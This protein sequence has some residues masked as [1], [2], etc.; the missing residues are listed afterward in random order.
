MNS[1]PKP[2]YIGLAVALFLALAYVVARRPGGASNDPSNEASHAPAT[3]DTTSPMVCV[4]RIEPLGGEVDV[5]AQMAGTLE[6]VTVK[7]GDRVEAG[8]PMASVEAR[9]EKAQ[10][11]LAKARLTRVQAGF[12]AEEIAATA[13]QRDAVAAELSLAESELRRALKLKEQNVISDDD[14]ETRQQRVAS[15]TKQVASLQKQFEAMKRGPLPEEV[16]VARAEVEVARANYQ[17]HEVLAPCGGTVLQLYRHTGDQVL[18]NYPTPILRMADTNRLQVRVEVNEAD[19]YRL[20]AG[21]EGSFTALGL[22]SETGRL[23]VR[24]VLPA[25]GPKRLFDPDTAAR[26]DTRTLQVLCDVTKT[27]QLVYPGQRVIVTFLPFRGNDQG[28]S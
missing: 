10:F 14:M 2:V 23:R 26:V 3:D 22:Q 27:R 5:S 18:L 11:E 28:G 25:F 19:V 24:T 9:R 15:L 12:G 16:A 7:E 17:V 1:W 4:G 6:A 20:N 21:T 8:A 13:A